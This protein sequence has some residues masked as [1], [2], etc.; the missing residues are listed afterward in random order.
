MRLS[1]VSERFKA[2][3]VPQIRIQFDPDRI[4]IF[5]VLKSLEIDY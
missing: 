3:V 4:A 5:V 2:M 1:V